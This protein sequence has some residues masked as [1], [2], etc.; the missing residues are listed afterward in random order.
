MPAE[1]DESRWQGPPG[2][3]QERETEYNS[4]NG[5]Q[6][7][8]FKQFPA[9]PAQ[10]PQPAYRRQAAGE[11]LY[12]VVGKNCQAS[13]ALSPDHLELAAPVLVKPHQRHPH[14]RRKELH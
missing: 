13:A 5:V 14:R 7:A 8:P 4:H 6:F 11:I 3:T 1:L 12:P 10:R 2:W 9:C